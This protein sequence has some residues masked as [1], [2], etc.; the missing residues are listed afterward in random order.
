MGICVLFLR[1]NSLDLNFAKKIAALLY[2]RLVPRTVSCDP[3][4]IIFFK[5]LSPASTV[6]PGSSDQDNILFHYYVIDID[7]AY[8]DLINVPQ[9]HVQFSTWD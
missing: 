3:F 7:V 1:Q 6:F 5:I 9:H 4:G 2:W 8:M